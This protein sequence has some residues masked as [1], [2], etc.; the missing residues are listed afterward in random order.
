MILVS[1][2]QG[3]LHGV[4]QHTP[5]AGEDFPSLKFNLLIL[6]QIKNRGGIEHLGRKKH[7]KTMNIK[8]LANVYSDYQQDGTAEDAREEGN[9]KVWR[10]ELRRHTFAVACVAECCTCNT[11]LFQTVRLHLPVQGAAVN[12]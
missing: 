1:F 9:K 3:T 10:P 6:K 4:C 2:D 5:G 12:A 8:L 11:L 7:E